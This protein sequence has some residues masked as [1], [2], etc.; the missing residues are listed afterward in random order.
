VH[1]FSQEEYGI[2]CLVQLSRHLG[3]GPLPIH[4]IAEAEGISPEYAAK[5]MR[6]LR[7]GGLVTATR[8]AGGGYRLVREAEEISVWEVIKVLG[9]GPL[10]SADFC[11]SHPGQMRDCVHTSDC[12]IRSLWHSISDLLGSALE[13][14]TLADLAG[15]E[16]SPVEWLMRMR[17]SAA[18]TPAAAGEGD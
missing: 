12:S 3:R 4:Q 15:A 8:G 6:A 11:D 10:F 5:L 17:T 18:R 13:G 14:I 1:L 2:R 9:G 7:Q 16:R